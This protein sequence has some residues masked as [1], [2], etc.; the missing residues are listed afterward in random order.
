MIS[1]LKK[2]GSYVYGFVTGKPEIEC[3]IDIDSII[4]SIEADEAVDT[5]KSKE[6][7]SYTTD[8]GDT[9]QH[10][11]G[12]VT[13]LYTDYGL[14]D[15]TLYF[16]LRDAP[17]EVL[18]EGHRVS[19]LAFRRQ[20]NEEWRV[21]RIYCIQDEN[22]EKCIADGD[23]DDE[24]DEVQVEDSVV[25]RKGVMRRN[26]VCQVTQREGREVILMPGNIRCSLDEVLAEFIPLEG[27]ICWLSANI[28]DQ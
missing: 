16:D 15:G 19:Y 24:K 27:N 21:R 4:S 7:L 9:C 12:T 10:R 28:T 3:T 1:L 25:Q 14:I 23:D 11:V 26:V 17:A 22:W 8:G 20:E 13:S 18:R 5:T 6:T 2:A